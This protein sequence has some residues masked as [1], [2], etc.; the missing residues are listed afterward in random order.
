M[1]RI[2][3]ESDWRFQSGALAIDAITP[4]IARSVPL[5]LPRSNGCSWRPGHVLW[6]MLLSLVGWSCFGAPVNQNRASQA[7]GHWLEMSPSPM[8]RTAGRSGKIRVGANASGEVRF[9]IVDLVPT[10]YIVMAADD[11]MEPI[12]AFSHEGRLATQAGDPLFDL[13][14]IDTEIRS[15]RLH[16][17]SRASQTASVD[18]HK[19]EMLAA[20]SS[21]S[22][23]AA[24]PS[25]GAVEPAASITTMDDV[26][27][28]PLVQ[29]QWNQNGYG[30]NL[31]IPNLDPAGCVATA[32][33][34]IMR[35]YQWPATG[36]GTASF[37]IS[38]EGVAQQAAL[39]GGDGAGGPYDW[40]D[41]VLVPD[42]NITTKQSQA[43]GALLY[44]AGVANNMAYSASGSGASLQ[45]AVIKNVFHYAN[46]ATAYVSNNSLA[47][48]ILALRTNLDAGL[49]VALAIASSSGIAGHEPVCDGYGFNLGTLYHHLNMGWGG[50]SNLWYNLPN[51]EAWAG[52][53][54]M[55]YNIIANCTYN[56][57]PT[58]S[59][60]IISGRVTDYYSNPVSGVTVTATAGSA[61]HTATT[62]Q[63][64]IFFLKGLAS[65]T[66]WSVSRTA[67]AT[68]YGPTQVSVTTGYSTDNSAVGNRVV[69]DFQA[70]LL[71][72]TR[73]PANQCVTAGSNA[74]FSIAASGTPSPVVQWQFSSNGGGTWT[75]LSDLA[76][77]S[78]AGTGTLTITGVT[79][80]MTGSRYRCVASNDVQGTL[81]SNAATLTIITP[82]SLWAAGGNWSGQLGDGSTS[83]C[84]TAELILP[85]GVASISAGDDFSLFVRTD[86][87]LW[88]TG[89]NSSGQLGD[90]TTTQQ[91]TPELI[92]SSG[93]AAVSAGGK[94]NRTI[95]P[96][97]H[98][99]GL[100]GGGFSLILKTDGS[101]WATG[102]NSSGQLG[103]GTTAQHVVPE[104]ILSG[105]VV[106]V[107]AGGNFS[108]IVKAD[109]SL[110]AM[111]NNSNGQL[112]DG[113]T[114]QRLVPELILP[115]GVAAVSAGP[116]FS[117]ITKAD[118]SLWAMGNNSN[119][120]LGD[121]TTTQQVVPELI[122]PGG[123]AEV[124]AGFTQSLIVKTDGSLWATGD[125]SSG[126][127][128]D[129]TTTQRVAPE[130]ILPGGV[131]AVS[132][133]WGFSLVL[134]SDG[135]LWA[136]GDNSSGQLGDGTTTS[137]R[138]PEFVAVNVQTIATGGSHS[139]VVGS[140]GV[141]LSAPAF[142]SQPSSQTTMAG[143][144]ATLAAAAWG[145]PIPTLQWQVSTNSGGWSTWTNLTDTAPYSGTATGTLAITGVTAGMNGYQYRCLASNSAQ[146]SVASSAAVLTVVPGEDVTSSGFTA[147]WNSVG[148]ATGYQLDV[149]TD[150]LFGSFV[151]GY[152]NLDVGDVTSIAVSGLSAGTTYYYRVRAYNSAGI[153]ANSSTISVT[154]SASV[155][156]TTPLIVSTLAGQPLT[157]GSNDGTGSAARFNYPCGVAADNAG[158]LYVADTDNQSI[159]K[160]VAATG[161]VITLAGQAGSSG[162][163]DGAG[164]AARFNGPSGVAVDS[165]GDVYVADTLNNTLRMV[166]PSGLVSTLAGLPGTAG[167]ADGTG[168]A[169][170]F[171]GP[172]GLAIDSGGNLYVADT[173]NHTIRKVVPSTGV[174]TTVA[175]LPG[176]SGSIDGFLALFD[177][178]SGV[179]IDGAGKLYVAD[180]ENHTIRVVQPS[181]LVSTVAGL[182]GSSGAADGT[183]S[184]ARFN[185]PSDV[186]VDSSGTLY[187]ADTD[188][189]TIREVVPSTGAVTT[190]AGVAGSSGSTN[191]SGSM[192]RFFH[193]VGIA[194]DSSGNLY[195]AD[196]DNHTIRVGYCQ[197]APT[198]QTQPQSQTVTTGSSVQFSVVASGRP[199]VTYQ[200]YFG[201]AAISGATN[202][203]CSL[204]S[205]QS[206]NAGNYTVVVSN[207]IGSVTSN[208]ATLTVNSSGGGGGGDV[209]S[210]GGGGGGGALSI[211]FCGA[212]LLLATARSCQRQIRWRN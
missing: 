111:G 77:Y 206:G 98:Q 42:L 154:T 156:V 95:V 145:V 27:V 210:S 105:G 31:Y 73:E 200:W 175:G 141:N 150:P 212:L 21:K 107:S 52:L 108:L 143:L 81:F 93:V 85:G 120:Q 164:S 205:V 124:S 40:A 7:A 69:D 197:V 114:T 76:P 133:S 202:S 71:A 6:T 87:S 49:P 62:N 159:R 188:N 51:M 26:R 80:A 1:G 43:I 9:Y 101:L 22:A 123:V 102:D 75:S 115:G 167:S 112:G 109:G 173:N 177:Y 94:S 195:I 110:W 146:G 135:S 201:G 125:N 131:A 104:L 34:Q 127:L 83:E 209:G 64:G 46:A 91:V 204:S 130:L 44:D 8:G 170:L 172:Q 152:Q 116:D 25:G 168:S 88:A 106:A 97:G 67:G 90:A 162:S 47:D 14:Q 10:G 99:P 103:D 178:P 39:R 58:V 56:I 179:A 63:R 126:Q 117:L 70:P 121:G 84:N 3:R 11:E 19:W 144:N 89:D 79:T 96:T 166:T 37:S 165:E 163:V 192:V 23:A 155:V 189:F 199:A 38:V 50:E 30:V 132:S 193:P 181:G 74:V 158:N 186:A 153:G 24:V 148:G 100:A 18:K 57:D 160:I 194:A 35:Y 180:T 161:A 187:V 59:G 66:T 60:E 208:V 17:A 82:G 65:N 157:S 138:A 176:T 191:G 196:T 86:G 198:I 20:S 78:G 185:S 142:T 4:A 149:S 113:T 139:L 184:A 147:L 5:M 134:K 171:R 29:S 28:D 151:S 13:L 33:A 12:I 48:T 55:D 15:R 207:A 182:T 169:A 128:G 122:L 36:V 32:W 118:G 129:G 136:M 140:G 41:M 190:L 68:V 174:V 45:T 183:S 92:L 119:G 211:V 203:S 54:F 53:E 16:A 61:T 2:S 137:C 72:I